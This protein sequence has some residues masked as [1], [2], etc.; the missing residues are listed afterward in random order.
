MSDVVSREEEL[1]SLHAFIG[2][3]EGGPAALVLEGEAGIGKS[4]LWLAGCEHGR[5]SGLRV[6]TSR[7]AEAERSLAHVGLG[8]LFDDVLDDVLPE[9]PAPRQRALEVALLREEA[10]GDR[11][12]P[13]A[14]G[15]AIRS[16]LQLLSADTPLLVA[17]DDVQWFDSSSAHALAFALRRLTSDRVGLLLARRLDD[18]AQPSALEQALGPMTVRRLPVGPLSLGALHRLLRDRFGSSFARQTLLRIHET[19]GG[20]PFFAL[21]LTRVLNAE[22]D[23]VQAV[24][25]TLEQ[26]VRARIADL[27]QST[28]EALVLA[29]AVGTTSEALLERAGVAPDAL[30]PAVAAHV[31]ERDH[32][33]VRFTH[34][35]LS[36]VLYMDLGEQRRAVHG[37][38][39]EVVEDPLLRARHLALSKDA[40][41]ADVAG[42]LDAAAIVAADRGAFAV[43]A[44]LAEQALRLTPPAQLEE[45]HRRALAA[46]RAHHA[47]GEW[48]RARTIA[49]D[50]LAAAAIASVRVEA[51]ILLAELESVNDA[52]ALLE[53]ALREAS[54]RPALQA[55]I[56]C[57]LA[58][59]T[60]FEASSG[61]VR[62]AL[63]LAD[64]LDDQMLRAHARA[65]QAIL[66]WFAGEGKAPQ[67]LPAIARDFAPAVGG[68]QLVQEATLAV[69][70][71]LAPS[72]SRSTA[73]GFFEREHE[74]WRERDEPRSARALWGLA[75]VEFW[76]GDWELAAAHAASAHDVSIQYGIEVPQDHLPIAI[77]AVHRG[78][79]DLARKHSERALEL[80]G[81]QFVLHP[82]QHMGVLGLAAL[83]SGDVSA[84]EE[85]LGKAEQRAME[86][87]WGEPSL[88]WWTPDHV[89]LLLEHEHIDEAMLLV[90]V[91]EGAAARVG[92]EWVLAQVTRCR[93]VVA[94]AQGKLDQADSL[95][96]R[97]VAQHEAVGDPYG[98]ARALLALGIVRRR[99]RQKRAS[100]DAI[101]AALSGFEQLGAATWVARARDELGR[102]GGR[103][104]ESG[105]TSAERRVATLVAEGRTNREVAAALF[106]GERTV[107]SHLTHIY[108]KLGVR[109]RTELARR[110]S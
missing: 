81:E 8:D 40:P 42:A 26:L 44:E 56:H 48:T 7:P 19:S 73:R 24:P 9:L 12:D 82:P 33:T 88:R 57:R 66:G 103:T 41:D 55:E 65:V 18:T 71:T 3:S 38:I 58:W 27:P 101:G 34:P 61:H 83:W 52:I 16:A 2:E 106:L 89:E 96:D 1:A 76:G 30:D 10:A 4:T 14:L 67:D 13:R 32:G 29:A 109:S 28:R 69:A 5:A 80:A 110:L 63:E 72:A 49:T 98:R 47:A 93:G 79:L 87:G 95:L 62:A 105:L 50:L 39:A 92:R 43:A 37:R 74:E 84:A 15:T 54:S 86:I 60:R 104:R 59:A 70:N 77:V 91:W 97:A 35:L 64:E 94:A 68:Q 90:D 51:L 102:I 22:I 6:L 53:E 25:A 45:R 20:N 31:I 75:W 46:A 85:W 23:P 107:A 78:E 99:E 36:S 108:A 21:E 17:I 11:V 100:R